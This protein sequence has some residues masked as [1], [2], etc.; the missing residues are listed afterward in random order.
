MDFMDFVNVIQVDNKIVVNVRFTVK[1]GAE[2]K[3]RFYSRNA[4]DL[5]KEHYPHLQFVQP[6][7]TSVTITNYVEPHEATWV[8]DIEKSLDQSLIDLANKNFQGLDL[9]ES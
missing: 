9:K 4:I 8:F 7:D 2:Q 6:E 3:R 5:A 1:K